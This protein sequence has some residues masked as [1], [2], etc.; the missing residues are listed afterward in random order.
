[1]PPYDLTIPV[2]LTLESGKIYQTQLHLQDQSLTQTLNVNEK[3]RR[4]AIDPHY[5]VFRELYLEEKPATLSQLTGAQHIAVISNPRDADALSFLKSW[6]SQIEGSLDPQS[7][8]SQ[9]PQDKPVLILGELGGLLPL[10][11][12]SCKA[13]GVEVNGPQITLGGQNF[14]LTQSAVVIAVR[15]KNN[16]A[17]TLTWVH[18]P[19]A[20]GSP[21][22]G[23]VAEWATRL[24]HYGKYSALVFTGKPNIYKSTWTAKDSPLTKNF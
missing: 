21:V 16:L 18:W 12:D 23:P 3:V 5:D 8:T 7:E 10:F 6:Q 4:V 2:E 13:Y 15:N 9:L 19:T 1:V 11:L 22:G 20:A 24:L 17:Q 14:D